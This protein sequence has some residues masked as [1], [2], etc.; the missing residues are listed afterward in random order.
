M[1]PFIR[2]FYFEISRIRGVKFCFL[3]IFALS[4]LVGC[5]G[6]NAD[7]PKMGTASGKI[8]LNGTPLT[9]CRINFNSA[10]TGVGAG[11]D[12]TE[13]GSYTLEGSL[14][15]GDYTLFITPPSDFTP[16]KAQAKSG[17]T[18]VPAKY[19]GEATSGLTAEVKEGESEYNFDLK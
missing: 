12:L 14:P 15:V 5:S 3:T 7:T 11:G 9:D 17:L 8:T 13:D 1:L 10:K 2:N 18:N 6:S 19:R 4:T 16:A